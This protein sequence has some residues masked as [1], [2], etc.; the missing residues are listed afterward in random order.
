[1][2]GEKREAHLCAQ[3]AAQEGSGLFGD[4]QNLFSTLFS[5]A[6]RPAGEK[7]CAHCG[8]TF[9]D[10]VRTGQLGCAVCYSGFTAELLP[11]LARI[12]GKTEHVGKVPKSQ[13]GALRLRSE[14]REARAQLKAAVEEQEFERAAGLRDSIR[15]ME[16]EL[17]EHH[18]NA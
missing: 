15:E 1:L 18:D 4:M 14:L 2:N 7:T 6:P 16:R 17:G 8:A 13:G 5:G 9:S 3:C 10:I 12:H 11:T